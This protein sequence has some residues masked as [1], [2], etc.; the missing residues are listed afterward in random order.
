MNEMEQL[1][2][3]RIDWV[4][5]SELTIA[6][7]T[8]PRFPGSALSDISVTARP[9]AGGSFPV[10]VVPQRFCAWRQSEGS[11][12]RSGLAKRLSTRPWDVR[13][14]ASRDSVQ[15]HAPDCCC[16]CGLSG[17]FHQPG[18]KCQVLCSPSPVAL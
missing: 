9:A 17:Q 3:E 7:A 4:Q 5:A 12:L 15:V 14:L 2:R 6:G 16:V 18:M 8:K 11:A 1:W 10:G 13:S